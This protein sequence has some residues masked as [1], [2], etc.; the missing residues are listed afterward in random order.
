MKVANLVTNN[1]YGNV[2][3]QCLDLIGSS[4]NTT[5]NFLQNTGSAGLEIDYRGGIN[6]NVYSGGSNIGSNGSAGVDWTNGDIIGFAMD[7]G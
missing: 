5:A 1:G 3:I 7:M 4:G 2:G 6:N